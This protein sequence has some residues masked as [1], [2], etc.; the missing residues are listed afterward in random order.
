[1]R[2][3]VIAKKV[4][5][6]RLFQADG[7]HVPVTVLQLDGLQVVG[8]RETDRDGY[9]AV[10]LGAGSAKAK[11]VAKPQRVAFGKAEVEPKAKVVEFRVADDALLDVGSEISADHFVAG[12]LVDVQGVTQGKGFA[13][14]MKRWGFGGL[15]ATHGVSVSHRSHGSTGN[16]QDPGRVFK[17]KKMAG[18]MGARNRTQQNL[19][20]VRTDPVRGLLFVKGSVPGHKG[21]WL[22]VSDAVKLPRHDSA[23]YPAGIVSK[24][25]PIDE[26]EVPVAGLVDEAAVHEIP[27]LPG[28]D[29]VAA[30]AAEQEAGAAAEAAAADAAEAEAA[31]AA[32][33]ADNEKAEAAEDSTKPAPDAD[34]GK[35]G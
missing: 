14:A 7:R 11:N 35:E 5:M 12:Q 30:I 16:R 26:T 13:G 27:A 17:N 34:E 15:R 28:D 24:D 31:D 22:T 9:T 4:G 1:M 10:Q 3:G 32:Q 21:S 8:R 25:R 23:P 20:I 33:A 2:T 18:H 19:E 29:E 6:T